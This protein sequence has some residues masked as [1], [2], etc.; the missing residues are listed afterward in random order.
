MRPL[1]SGDLEEILQRTRPLWDE[2]RGARIFLTGGTGFFGCWLTESF[3]H[4]N[5][6]LALGARLVLLTR[7]RD[8]FAARAPHLAA[9]PEV[10][11]VVGDAKD[12]AFPSGSFELAAHVA[13]ETR[14]NYGVV[15]PRDLLA[16]NLTGTRR[17]LDFVAAAGVGR[18]LFTSSGAAYGRQPSELERLRE[19]VRLAPDPMEPGAAYGESKRA[20]EVL[21]A[22]AT[23]PGRCEGKVARCFAFVGPHLPL[24][25]NYA[26]GNFLNDALAGRPL[27][28]A[29]DGTPRRSYLYAADLAAWLWTILLR[30]A[31]ARVYNVGAE[32]HHSIREIAEI[33]RAE[34]SPGSS[35][36]VAGRAVPG[37]AVSRYVPDTSRARD[38]LRLDEWVGLAE[39][40]RRTAAWHRGA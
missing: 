14:P 17:F 38:E 24:D 6:R 16:G 4:A 30:G 25:A 39:A 37:A 13:T 3:V 1:A 34:V 7:D 5:R 40:I 26:I 11:I 9:A 33:V 36:D 20:S 19:D 8:R 29:G 35:I 32:R 22:A 15:E 28:I 21:C 2:V 18:F 23:V 31:P 12:F 10:G 27:R